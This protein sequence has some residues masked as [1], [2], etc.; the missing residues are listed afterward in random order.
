[1]KKE[2]AGMTTSSL[3]SSQL[4]VTPTLLALY[5]GNRGLAFASVT[6]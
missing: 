2:N 6:A 3:L 1:M 5:L 4:A